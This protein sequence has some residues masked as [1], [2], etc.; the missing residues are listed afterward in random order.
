[1]P[2]SFWSVAIAVQFRGCSVFFF[3]GYEFLIACNSKLC[4]CCMYSIFFCAISAWYERRRKQ[5]RSLGAVARAPPFSCTTDIPELAI[6]L[7]AISRRSFNLESQRQYNLAGVLFVGRHSNSVSLE[8]HFVS[9]GYEL[10]IACDCILCKLCFCRIFFVFCPIFSF[11]EL[12][13]AS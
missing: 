10:A 1:M 12:L 5:K 9:C 13:S 8:L 2:I 11:R 3:C 6:V 4:N 7:L